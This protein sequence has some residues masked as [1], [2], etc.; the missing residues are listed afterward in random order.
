[1]SIISG[2]P[3]FKVP[4]LVPDGTVNVYASGIIAS[5]NQGCYLIS[6]NYALIGNITL[7]QAQIY[8]NGPIGVGT[9]VGTVFKTN[10]ILIDGATTNVIYRNLLTTLVVTTDNSPI[11]FQF[12]NT[13]TYGT[14]TLGVYPQNA[15][16][17]YMTFVKI[18]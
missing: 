1:M 15:N 3:T 2:F 10:P 11:Y 7:C 8:I 6:F 4:I 14:T 9:L 12:S 16:Y 17:N 18:E 13:G 5:L